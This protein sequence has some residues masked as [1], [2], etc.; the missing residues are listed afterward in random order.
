MNLFT[1]RTLAFCVGALIVVVLGWLSGYDYNERGEA[2]S[3]TFIFSI[4]SGFV[5]AAYPFEKDAA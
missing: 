1:K 5:M 4:A 3:L 2:A